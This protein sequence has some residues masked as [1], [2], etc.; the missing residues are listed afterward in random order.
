MYQKLCDVNLGLKCKFWLKN[1]YTLKFSTKNSRYRTL[2]HL[3][4][5]N[6][7]TYLIL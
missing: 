5:P 3:R 4:W 7:Q 2:T 1:V 6:D